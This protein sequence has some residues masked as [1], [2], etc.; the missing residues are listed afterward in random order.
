MP[1][2]IVIDDQTGLQGLLCQILLDAGY[3]VRS[4]AQRSMALKVLDEGRPSIVIMDWSQD[5][6]SGMTARQFIDIVHKKYVEVECIVTTTHEGVA[7]SASDIGIRHVL[8]K[9]FQVDE[10]L[11]VVGN[12]AAGVAKAS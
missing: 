3:S 11:S 1:N 2:I 4:T 7:E 10:L 9:P 5:G 8:R 12:C 6:I